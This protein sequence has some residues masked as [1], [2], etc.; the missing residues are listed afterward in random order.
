MTELP[1]VKFEKLNLSEYSHAGEGTGYPLD[2]AMGQFSTLLETTNAMVAIYDPDDKLCFANS[3]FRDAF[4][5]AD[6][7]II[8]WPDIMRRNFALNRGT[9]LKTD[10]IEAWI[11]SVESRRGKTTNRTFEMDLHDGRWFWVK[12][13]VQP[14]GWMLFVGLNITS[15]R[16]DERELRMDRDYAVKASHTDDLTGVSNR[17]HIFDLMADAIAGATARDG[18]GGCAC[19]LDIDHFKQINDRFGH[20]M[21]DRVL[22]G[23]ARTIR[24][25]VRLADGFG[26]VGGEEFLLIMPG[27]NLSE[28]VAIVTRAFEKLDES[29]LIPHAPDRRITFSAGLTVMTPTDTPEAVYR[30]C[31]E[32][33]Y[34]AKDGGRNQL[35]IHEG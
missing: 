15:V 22:S 8:A 13:T 7:E 24:D 4:Y 30:R 34:A 28:G 16:T 6:G 11:L 32:K 17:R 33:L 10:D 5:L 18:Q 29:Q 27:V 1:R 25:A 20:Q 26:R 35:Q 14:N 12:E 21:G 9:I 31:D 19:L 2:R 3:A 23:F